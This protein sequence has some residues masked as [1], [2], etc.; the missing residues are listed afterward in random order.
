MSTKVWHPE[1]RTAR[2]SAPTLQMSE[3][4]AWTYLA[5]VWTN[6]YRARRCRAAGPDDQIWTGLCEG[7][8]YLRAKRRITRQTYQVMIRTLKD[9]VVRSGRND[10]LAWPLTI[11]G[12]QHRARF[13]RQMARMR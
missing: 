12:A 7:V 5:E 13:C 9:M 3:S 10:C 6:A 2:R 11:K 8:D 1:H 4:E